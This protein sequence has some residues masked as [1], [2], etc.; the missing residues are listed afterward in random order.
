MKKLNEKIRTECPLL[1]KRVA[2]TGTSRTK[3][4]GETG[5]AASFHHARGRYV[6]VLEN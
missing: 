6:V 5:T 4:N 2:V 1:E 3:L